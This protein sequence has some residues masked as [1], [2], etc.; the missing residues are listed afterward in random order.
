MRQFYTL[1][2]F[3]DT[4]LCGNPLAIVLDADGLDS[5]QMQAIAGEFNLSETVFVTPPIDN[6]NNAA[7]RIFTPKKELPFAGHPT[8]GTA[9]LLAHLDGLEAGHSRDLVLEENV[10]PVGCTIERDGDF[11]QARFLLP[12]LPTRK[13]VDLDLAQLAGALGISSDQLG[14]QGHTNAVCDAGVPFPTFGV[15]NLPAMEAIKVNQDTLDKCFEKT[16]FSASAYVYCKQCV[17]HDSDYHVRLFAPSF[18]ISEDPAT[19]GAAAAFAA[20]IMACDK[21][22]EGH[23]LLILEQGLEMGRPSRIE[24]GIEVSEGKLIGGS[25]GGRAVIISQGE[26]Y[27]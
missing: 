1:D 26:L 17:N 10:G 14:I 21:P 7:I 27:L 16:D 25:I 3:T 4:S 11:S 20:Q 6:K 2:V 12:K 22:S 24:L 15:K 18:G 19:G 5:D 9:I 8:V 13:P 23:H